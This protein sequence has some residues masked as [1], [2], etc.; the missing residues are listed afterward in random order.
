MKTYIVTEV[1][2]EPFELEAATVK[3]D[4]QTQRATFCDEDGN[5]VGWFLNITFRVK[6]A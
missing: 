6:S 4:Q 2:K 1:G 3:I 5:I